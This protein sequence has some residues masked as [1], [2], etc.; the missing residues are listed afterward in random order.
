[1]L[2][3]F[4]IEE[5]KTEI[6][7]LRDKLRNCELRNLKSGDERFVG[8]WK[9]VSFEYRSKDQVTYP[10][11]KDPVGYRMYN[12]DGYMAVAF[13]AS[14]R[15]RFSSMDL[16]G[17]TAEEIVAAAGS[18]FSYCG[19]YEVTEDK[20]IHH[21]EVSFYPNWVGEKQVRFYKFEDDKLI[22]STPP[23]N[24]AGKQQSGY[25]IWKRIK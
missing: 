1:V 22:L 20:V 8:T 4:K 23:M 11:G 13:M 18:Y 19:K 21:V 16:T 24:A 5:L 6:S 3:D 2:S 9:L 17:G 14:N 15:R 7:N 10:F 12:D 25:L